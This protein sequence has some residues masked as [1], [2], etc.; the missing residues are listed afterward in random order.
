MAIV[1]TESTQVQMGKTTV[2]QTVE[3]VLATTQASVW[4]IS[5]M[6]SNGTAQQKDKGREHGDL[7][8]G[9]V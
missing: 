5:P 7:Q 8:I 4:E 3:H 9:T 6:E 1:G 2:S